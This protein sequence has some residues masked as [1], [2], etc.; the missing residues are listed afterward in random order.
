MDLILFQ[1]GDPGF[2]KGLLAADASGG[3][4]NDRF[5]PLQLGQFIEL[6]S[7]SQGINNPTQITV[8]PIITEFTCVKYLDKT[9]VRLYDY[10]LRA[11]ALG[12]GE[13]QPS[14]LYILRNSGDQ[15]ANIM[16]I[17]LRDAIV[18]EIQFQTNPN[19]M[20]TEQFKLSFTEILWTYS[21]Q[22]GDIKSGEI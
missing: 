11:Q 18:T 5:K 8:K 13:K 6:V 9:S 21:M 17:K 22:A 2:F 15:T 19:D 3:L 12:T 7:V 14:Y 4:I 16:T 10:C 1:P 20:P